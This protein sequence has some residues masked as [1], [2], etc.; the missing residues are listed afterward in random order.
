M[1]RTL[2]ISL[3]TIFLLFF[4]AAVGLATHTNPRSALEPAIATAI[5][6]GLVQQVRHLIVWRSSASEVFDEIV[7][8]RWFAIGWRL[9]LVA[10]I[11]TCLVVGVLVSRAMLR[12]P[13]REQLW[14]HL[15]YLAL[16]PV[17]IIIVLCNSIARW[18]SASPIPAKR[19][20]R[21]AMLWAI[22]LV[23]G[24]VTLVDATATQFF[25]HRGLSNIEAA[26][27]PAFRRPDVYPDL[28]AEQYRPV[29]LAS[30]AV[31]CLLVATAVL[32][33]SSSRC[34]ARW[35]IAARCVLFVALL[36]PPVVFA[37]WYYSTEFHRLSPEIAGAGQAAIWTDWLI[38]AILVLT[39]ATIGAYLL[40]R[41][42]NT[43][44][45]TADLSDN[46][47][48]TAFHESFYCLAIIGLNAVCSVVAYIRYHLSIKSNLGLTVWN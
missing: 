34:A 15:E 12:L 20:S 40:S 35:M 18:Q 45:I 39:M 37:S 2:R 29:W 21:V 14:F 32:L 8:A 9:V 10:L 5:A 27:P 46:L 4:C 6:I 43:V 41:S 31:T 17:C 47:E 3:R 1:R 7:F 13:E 25:V 36:V 44:E 23:I 28:A 33:W 11:V 38:G 19:R 30:A 16:L 26:S 24:T 22:G 48:R 42:N